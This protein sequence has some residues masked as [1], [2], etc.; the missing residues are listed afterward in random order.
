MN[1]EP[2]PSPV[3]ESPNQMVAKFRDILEG[4]L[5]SHAPIRREKVGKKPA[6]WI[7]PHIKRFME[8][9]DEL[10]NI[11]KRIETLSNHINL[12]ETR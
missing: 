8:R 10:R 5:K 7:T 12:C 11:L 4:L 1:W 6:P 9:R 2:L 3:S